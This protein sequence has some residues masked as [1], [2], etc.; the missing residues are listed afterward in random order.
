MKKFMIKKKY[1]IVII[2]IALILLSFSAFLLIPKNIEVIKNSVVKIVVYDKENNQIATGSGF[3]AYYKNYIVTNY[4]VISGAYRI[5]VVSDDKDVYDVVDIVIFDA[6][7]DLAIIETTGDFKPMTLAT[8]K[9]L[10]AG[11]EVATIGSPQGMLNTVSTGVISNADEENYIRFT[12]PISP[13]SS[14]GVL[15]NSKNKV[16]GITTATYNSL[17]AQ[18]IN[19]ARSV[20]K[21]EDLYRA[22]KDKKYAI[23]DSK[24]V[25]ECLPG[26]FDDDNR[27]RLDIRNC[28]FTGYTKYTTNNINDFYKLTS[29][30]SLF[31]LSL[32]DLDD[33]FAKLFNNMDYSDKGLVTTIFDELLE[34]ETCDNKEEYFCLPDK[35]ADTFK[36][37]SNYQYVFELNVLKRYEF[38]IFLV[39]INGCNNRKEIFDFIN[40]LNISAGKKVIL[41]LKFGGYKFSELSDDD[42]DELFEYLNNITNNNEFLDT[43]LEDLGYSIQYNDDGTITAHW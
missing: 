13:G 25:N 43:L 1:Y 18:N 33:S 28:D 15:L 2:I 24:N 6:L 16:I 20:E 14:G 42:K 38:A 10:K 32:Q 30:I 23:V 7:D 3:C 36:S 26:I 11:Q 19:F 9:N 40:S 5:E 27:N 8:G 35:H 17:E 34:F 21:L 41:L 39:K 29:K 31:E 4:H 12:A 22:L 37:W